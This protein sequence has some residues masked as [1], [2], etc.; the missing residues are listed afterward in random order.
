M[1]KLLFRKSILVAGVS[2]LLLGLPS[3]GDSDSVTTSS[4]VLSTATDIRITGAAD[5]K[6][7]T[8]GTAGESFFV[9][10]NSAQSWTLTLVP[11][12]A[13]EWLSLGANAGN[14]ALDEGVSVTL[15]QNKGEQREAKIVLTSADNT[16]SE[17]LIVQQGVASAST[18]IP[19]VPEGSDVVL[20]AGEHILGDAFLPEIPR[21]MGGNNMYFVTYKTA[22]GKPN[23]SLEYDVNRRHARWV[24]YSWDKETSKDVT[25]RN[26]SF[27]W[28]N[29]IPSQYST[30]NWFSGSGFSRGHLV[31]SNDR[32]YSKEAN[33][34]TFYYANMS[35]QRQPHNEGV[36]LQ[37]E[38]LLQGWARNGLAYDALYVTK[39]GTIDDAQI[40]ATKVR[41]VIV[42]PKYYW[43]AV[44]LKRGTEYHGIAFWTEHNQPK[45]VS[46]VS[47]LAITIDELEKRT[48]IDLYPNLENTAETQVEAEAHTAFRWPGL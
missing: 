33:M 21:L 38:S 22:D 44:V 39:G 13:S 4:E 32:Q 19:V 15:A 28:D 3:C 47:S 41:N 23:F 26:D 35:P 29:I 11:S 25:G 34:Q 1:T 24:A 2:L 20:P 14:I 10:V 9:K 43:M 36:W 27:R 48:G 30:D 46:S 17:L 6:I 5:S 16:T 45:R 31:A 7:R 8:T 37:L 12:S 40:E 42:V 18:P